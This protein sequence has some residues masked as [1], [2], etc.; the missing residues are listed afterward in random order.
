MPFEVIGDEEYA[1]MQG[2]EGPEGYEV[3][4]ADVMGADVMGHSPYHRMGAVWGPARYPVV[5]A[6][7]PAN[8]ALVKVQRPPWRNR[9]LAPGVIAPDQGL[10]PL[11]M[12]GTTGTDT[13]TSALNPITFEGQIQKPFRGERLLVRTVRTG[14]S[15]TGILTG[16][17]F[18]GTDLQQLDVQ[19]FDIESVGAVT[20]FG[21]RLTMKPAQPGVFI[22]LVV[23]LA[24][25]LA[26]ADT[27]LASITLLGRNVH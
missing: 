1:E 26:A 5:G 4:G 23:T 2:Y 22:R 25:A 24:P 18:I 3:E 20:G 17:L 19:G 11:P 27:I 7:A 12:H 13:F 15:A 9:Q 16:Q 10:L 14:V 8:A 21:V 6:A